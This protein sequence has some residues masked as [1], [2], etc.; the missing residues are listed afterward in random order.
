MIK[1]ITLLKESILE[2]KFE[3]VAIWP[4]KGAPRGTTQAG[5]RAFDIYIGNPD[6]IR[7]MAKTPMGKPGKMTSF[8]YDG[9]GSANK[10]YEWDADTSQWDVWK[11]MNYLSLTPDNHIHWYHGKAPGGIFKDKTGKLLPGATGIPLPDLTIKG[12]GVMVYKA[13]LLDPTVGYILSDKSSTDKIREYVYEPLM[14][15]KDFIWIAAGGTGGLDYDD[16]VI[17]NP[18]HAD[19]KKVK[20]DFEKEHEGAKFYYSKNFPK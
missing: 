3:D 13:V 20:Q 10:D 9:P 4:A 5:A 17:I 11:N 8:S 1:L 7:K 14:N 12:F 16:I 19:V 15:D 6:V 2:A 18:K